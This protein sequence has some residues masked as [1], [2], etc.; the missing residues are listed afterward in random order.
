MALGI[1]KL[2]QRDGVLKLMEALRL[3]MFPMATA[4]ATELFKAGQR[5]GILS[6]QA[7]EPFISYISRRR[8]WYELL[9]QL[10]PHENP[11]NSQRR[12]VGPRQPD[13]IREVMI[14]T[15]TFNNHKSDTVAEALVK[16]HALAHGLKSPDTQHKKGKGICILTSSME[17][18]CRREKEHVEKD[19]TCSNER[20]QNDHWEETRKHV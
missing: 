15:S 3:H 11:T 4:E 13:T 18:R 5:P 12:T 9:K 1:G 19:E 16:Q 8:R 20:Q 14:M 7:G 2:S 17:P 6:R 10:D